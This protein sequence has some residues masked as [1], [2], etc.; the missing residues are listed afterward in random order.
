VSQE[1]GRSGGEDQLVGSLLLASLLLW[2][3]CYVWIS[4]RRHKVPISVAEQAVR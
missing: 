4:N 1:K 3:A 2:F